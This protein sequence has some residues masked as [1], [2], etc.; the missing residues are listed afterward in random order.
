MSIIR[1]SILKAISISKSQ[2]D[3]QI[4]YSFLY[5]EFVYLYRFKGLFK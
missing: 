5:N 1:S 2:D 3:N 4:T